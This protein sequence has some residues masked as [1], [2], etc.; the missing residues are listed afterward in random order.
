MQ[1]G[2]DICLVLHS[3]AGLPGCEAVNRIVQA[4]GLQSGPNRPG[5]LVKVIF[6]SAHHTPTGL[7]MDV[8][9]Y[10]GPANPYFKLDFETN[11]STHNSTFEAFFNDFSTPE[12]AQPYL[13]EIKPMYYIPG[14]GGITSEE[15]KQVPRGI[16]G[17]RRDVSIV[18]ALQ[19]QMWS[20]FGEEI[21]WVDMGHT[22]FPAKPEY[23]ADVLIDVLNKP[24]KHE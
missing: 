14:G 1:S 7:I 5:R 8:K 17:T 11:M 10:I 9:N 4:G 24:G 19:E 16:I 3:Y 2:Q 21:V 18:P 15:W 13:D 6:F 20:E 22:P 12:E 23:V